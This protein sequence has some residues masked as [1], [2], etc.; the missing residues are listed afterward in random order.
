[1]KLN[2][3]SVRIYR[4]LRIV[5]HL[6][7]AGAAILFLY[8]W[9]SLKSRL[10]IERRWS[11]GFLSILNI[12]VRVRGE[13]PDL[14]SENIMLVSNHV[15]WLDI[16]LLSAIH[17]A[18]FVSKAEVRSWPIIGWLAYKTGTLFIDRKKRHD[19]GRINDQ[20]STVLA[21]GGCLAVFPE[22]TTTDGSKLKRFHASLLQPAIHSRSHLWPV[23]I[24]YRHADG[25]LNTAPAYIDELT[26]VNSLSLVLAQSIIYAELEFMS[27][28]P[29]QGKTRRELAIETES[30]IATA[31]NFRG[32]LHKEQL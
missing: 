7:Y 26:F 17:P 27:P 30:I 21:E 8:K 3:Y 5:M 28:I 13:V 24:R 16:H 1:M 6:M 9:M 12:K 2:N 25:S 20:M 31:L 14:F 15:S 23:A 11:N 4:V 10:Q 18:R 22:G 19:T 29:A 32:E